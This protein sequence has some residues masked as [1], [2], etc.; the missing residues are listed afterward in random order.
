MDI[1]GVWIDHTGRGAVRIARCGDRM[2]GH[3]FWL[4]TPNDERGR[5]LR[6]IRNPDESKRRNQICGTQILGDLTPVGRTGIGTVWGRGWIYNPE[7]GKRYNAEVKLQSPNDLSVMGYLGFRFLNETHIWR[8]A[9]TT[10]AQCQQ[11]GA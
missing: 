6:D 3:I 11:S 2:C 5:P 8:R 1:E 7:D 4:R 10:V 9:P